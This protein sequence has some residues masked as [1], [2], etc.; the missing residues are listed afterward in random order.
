MHTEPPAATPV[1]AA[2][3]LPS[4]PAS[5]NK[6]NPTASNPEPAKDSNSEDSNNEDSNSE[7]PAKVA[8]V[9]AKATSGA[10]TKKTK[11]VVKKKT[12]KP[13]KQST[14]TAPATPTRKRKAETPGERSPD[15]ME[16][17]LY[18]CACD[19]EDIFNKRRATNIVPYESDYFRAD[20][21][22]WPFYP[23]HC[24][25]CKKTFRRKQDDSIK[26]TPGLQ[27]HCCNNSM[28]HREHECVA[29]WCGPCFTAKQDGAKEKRGS[30]RK[31]IL[32]V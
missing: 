15:R 29:A 6:E 8:K 26:W 17:G 18:S 30:K 13:K 24:L 16:N 28:N 5:N 7:P 12:T 2:N 21:L 9:S 3:E 22:D 23:T 1:P 25:D 32:S 11:K 20:R 14:P 4:E 10:K 19:H 31:T 27:I